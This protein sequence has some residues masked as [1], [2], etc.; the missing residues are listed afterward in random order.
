M[1]EKLDNQEK[2]K[3][4]R[5]E[6]GRLLP[7]N[8]ANPKGRPVGKTLKEYSAQKFR[9]MTDDEKEEWL[10]TNRISGDTKWKMAEGNPQSD[11][12]VKGEIESKIISVDE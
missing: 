6:K 5:D 4:A 8:T 7:G 3:P 10:K 9:E 1:S 12:E 11:V 2:N